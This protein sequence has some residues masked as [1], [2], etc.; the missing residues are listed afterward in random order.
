MP[1]VNREQFKE[2]AARYVAEI[3]SG[4][5]VRD[6][7]KENIIQTP[8]EM[9]ILVP[10]DRP[11][12][13]LNIDELRYMSRSVIDCATM[14][15]TNAVSSDYKSYWGWVAAVVSQAIM[16]EDSEVPIELFDDYSRIVHSTLLTDRHTALS[17]ENRKLSEQIDMYNPSINAI[18]RGSGLSAASTSSFPILEGLL[19][20]HC[21]DLEVN[22]RSN[23]YKGFRKLTNDTK[24]S[25]MVKEIL[26]EVDRL[27]RYDTE[28]L[29][30]KMAGIPDL[31]DKDSF[32]WL[33]KE[34]RNYNIHGEGST[35]AIGSIGLTLCTLVML[36]MISEESYREYKSS[37]IQSIRR[38]WN[39]PV[40][41]PMWAAAFYP[42]RRT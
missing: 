24:V 13:D 7:G 36:D 3:D 10:N 38:K 29:N 19:K 25:P 14:S 42:I 16:S 27:E 11:V 20:R 40:P 28:V 5:V 33:V 15:H 6:E 1:E 37:A 34:Q 18:A 39:Q 23:I 30:R 26:L 22:Q 12:H 35:Q 4:S 8:R 2:R 41:H 9:E 32:L 21:T 31:T 17:M